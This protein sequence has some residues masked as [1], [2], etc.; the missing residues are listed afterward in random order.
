MSTQDVG[1]LTLDS[2]PIPSWCD[3]WRGDSN[4]LLV[5]PHGGRRRPLDPTAP[6]ANARVN[7]VYTPEITR[8]LAARL[9]AGGIVNAAM[10]RNTL[11][12]NRTSQ[13]RRAARWYL[14]LLVREIE[15]IIARH[16]SV[17]VVFV[18]GWNTGRP[19]CDIGIGATETPSGL[20]IPDGASLTI[21]QEYLEHRIGA[22]RAACANEGID[23]F[24]GARYPAS[25]P[26]N[27]L[28]LFRAHTRYPDDPEVRRLAAWAAAAQVDA[29]QLELGIPLRWPGEWCD[30]FLDVMT[31]V[32]RKVAAATPQPAGLCTAPGEDASPSVASPASMS[33]WRPGPA[34]LTTTPE[35]TTKALQF[36]D[37][38]RDVGVLAGVGS[39]GAATAGRLLVFLG[40][41]RIALF[42]GE[43]FSGR[44]NRVGPLR[45]VPTTGGVRLQFDGPMLMLDDAAVYLDLEDAFAKSR[46]VRA[47]LDVHFGA[48]HRTGGGTELQFGAVTGELDLEE[49][50]VIATRAFGNVALLRGGEGHAMVAADFGRRGAVVAR[51]SADRTPA[52]V[53]F[54]DGATP[55]DGTH[56]TVTTKADRYTPETLAWHAPDQPPLMGRPMSCMAILRS[57]GRGQYLR[58][59][60][61]VAQFTWGTDEGYGFYEYAASLS[62]R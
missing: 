23:A 11:D 59:A 39:L 58:V 43:D 8:A 35:V 22:L 21:G 7:D 56:L 51:G 19:T 41:Q 45:F 60:F 25:H 3:H 32:F 55:V 9:E 12:L 57:T 26:N 40:G 10:D 5:A 13:V 54:Q 16:G 46:L 61:G 18:H 48:T 53:Y 1:G 49:R 17:Q 4:V 6:P 62:S 29:W 20:V 28:Q 38:A 42:T 47:T 36:Y 34:E 30:R 37:P 52:A 24:L 50:R 15:V 33:R 31:R 27:V 14:R 2:E 44:G